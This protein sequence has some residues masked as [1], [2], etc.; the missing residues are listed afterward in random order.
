MCFSAPASFAVAA[1]TGFVGVLTLPKASTRQEIPLASVPLIFAAQQSIEGVL[2]LLLAR[3]GE[4]AL[5]GPLANIF[6]FFALVVWPAWASLAIGLIEHDRWRRLALA[7]LF[8]LAIPV[9][10]FNL[11]EISLHPY[12]VCI[13]QH[14]LSYTNGTASSLFEFGAYIVCTCC[15]F[16]FSSHMAMRIFGAIVAVGLA[17]STF[18]Y[19]V[20]Y[21]SVWCFFA[22]AGSVTIYLY[23]VAAHK[24]DAA[25]GTA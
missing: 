6:M 15:P 8:A 5:I 19:L 2:W 24:Q 13:L 20:T 1:G 18:F 16:L 12:G 9:A 21:L 25:R 11:R 10:V 23:F 22:A 3:D 7:V 17:I 4:T 14:S